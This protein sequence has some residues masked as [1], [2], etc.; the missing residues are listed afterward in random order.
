MKPIPIQEHE[1]ESFD[2]SKVIPAVRRIPRQLNEGFGNI[3]DFPTA[4]SVEL[5]I[6]NKQYVLTSFRGKIREWRKLD[7]LEKW[8]ISKGFIEFHC[9]L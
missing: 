4:W 1:L 7:S 2:T 6:E 5:R 3:S 8:L 9:Y